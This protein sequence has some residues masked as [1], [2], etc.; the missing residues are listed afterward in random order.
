[1]G[2]ATALPDIC[3]CNPGMSE[4]VKCLSY[5]INYQ[6]SLY[7]DHIVIISTRYIQRIF[8]IV[9][10]SLLYPCIDFAG[11]LETVSLWHNYFY[12]L[13][14]IFQITPMMFFIWRTHQH[15]MLIFKLIE[16]YYV[17]SDKPDDKIEWKR[18]YLYQ[19]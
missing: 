10:T 3:S 1:M 11:I 2:V 9:Y 6:Y 16:I 13:Y 18:F 5:Q 19:L 17:Y 15:A 14:E 12:I 4:L 8:H 7:T